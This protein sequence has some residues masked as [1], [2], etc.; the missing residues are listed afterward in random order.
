MDNVTSRERKAQTAVAEFE[1][2]F[3]S[4][5]HDL[6]LLNVGESAGIIDNYLSDHFGSL[7]GVDID[8]LAI[9]YQLELVSPPDDDLS[10][11]MVFFQGYGHNLVTR[12]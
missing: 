4:S 6:C 3:K 10:F 7:V 11:F 1:D 8:E 2:F 12:Y 5:L 9:A